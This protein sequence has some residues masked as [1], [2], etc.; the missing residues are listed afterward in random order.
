M[1]YRII[2]VEVNLE[3]QL[4]PDHEIPQIAGSEKNGIR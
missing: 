1:V 3:K 4:G 2:S